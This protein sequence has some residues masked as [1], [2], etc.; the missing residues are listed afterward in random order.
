M[1]RFTILLP[2]ADEQNKH[3]NRFA[4][5]VF[6]YR[7]RTTFNFFHG[8][9]TDRRA[10]IDRIHRLIEIEGEDFIADIVGSQEGVTQLK[11]LYSAQRM[12]ARKRYDPSD[13]Y[14]ALD[15]PGLPT[16]AQRR[17]LEN[18][19][20]ISGLF[21]VLRPDDLIP[22]Y[23][24]PIGAT[25]PEVGAV[26]DYWR[27]LVS[28]LINSSVEGAFVWDLLDDVHRS[29]W[30]DEKRYETYVRVHFYDRR[31]KV[32]LTDTR[33][34]RGYLVN[35]LVQ[36]NHVNFNA[37]RSWTGKTTQGFRFDEARSQLDDPHNS[38]VIMSRR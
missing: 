32:M 2:C 18:T 10:L 15:F 26:T 35:H 8:L 5:D 29:V 12:A 25:L 24:L 1:G 9:I 13:L 14:A 33:K 20:I 23:A 36:Q 17:F 21:G 19:V 7:E 11:N 38:V 22:Q 3:G 6:D 37:I 28:P 31:K 16:G 34:I 4:P 27:P 30:V